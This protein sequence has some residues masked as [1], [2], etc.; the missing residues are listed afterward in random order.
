MSKSVLCSISVKIEKM[1][2]LKHNQISNP[3]RI[4]LVKKKKKKEY[5]SSRVPSCEQFPFHMTCWYK[6][7][8][9]LAGDRQGT[10]CHSFPGIWDWD[11]EAASLSFYV[12]GHLIYQGAATFPHVMEKQRKWAVE[13]EEHRCISREK[14]QRWSSPDFP[15]PLTTHLNFLRPPVP[16]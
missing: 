9:L 10:S 1:A 15:V 6:T 3:K 11:S 14:T 8:F 7:L 4:L 16:S 12:A 13:R 2:F 5:Y